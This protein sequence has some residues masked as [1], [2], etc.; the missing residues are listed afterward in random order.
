VVANTELG[1]VIVK[2][3]KDVEVTGVEATGVIGTVL[4]WGLID[5]FQNPNWTD[6]LDTQ[7]PNW[8]DV[9]DTQNPNWTEIA[10]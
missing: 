3:D 6:I 5:D 4:V 8:V 1:S 2:I 7:G 9:D 10:A